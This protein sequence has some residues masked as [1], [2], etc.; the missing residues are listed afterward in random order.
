MTL[1]SKV[2]ITIL[3]T[4]LFACGSIDQ[5]SNVRTSGSNFK[6]NIIAGKGDVVLE[7]IRQ[8]NMPNAFGKADLFGRKR[9]VGT[10]SVIYL[11]LNGSNAVFLRRDVDISSSKTTMNSSP[12]V[13]NQSS[14]SYHTGNVGGTSYSGTSTTYNAPI[15]LPPNT[16]KD[17]ITGIREME[18]TIAILGENNFALI[19][20]KI[21]ELVSAD[22]NQVVFKLS[23]PE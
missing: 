4:L 17:R 7:V 11:G 9:D 21:M 15:F 3:S 13:I 23:D 20:G 6:G 22:N 5:S 12:S 16:P 19:A 8:E 1:N 18:I 2:L 14:T 10:T